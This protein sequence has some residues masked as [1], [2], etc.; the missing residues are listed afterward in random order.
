MLDPLE[1]HIID[2]TQFQSRPPSHKPEVPTITIKTVRRNSDWEASPNE[3]RYSVLNATSVNG[4]TYIPNE[5]PADISTNSKRHSK[6]LHSTKGK[7]IPMHRV[8][9]T[10]DVGVAMTRKDQYSHQHRYLKHT[11]RVETL[12][13]GREGAP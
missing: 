8:D 1:H 2:P 10:I 3:R 11:E 4:N 7:T 9:N 12:S 13:Q 6:Y 5:E